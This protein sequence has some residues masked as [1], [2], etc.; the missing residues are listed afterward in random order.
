M[1]FKHQLMLGGALVVGAFAAGAHAQTR[2]TTA[3]A[4]STNTIEELVVTAEKREQ[5]LQDVPVAVSA[6]T[7]SKRELVGINSIQD[8]TNFTPGLQYNSSTDRVSLRG[9]GRQTNVLSADASVANYNDGVYETFAVQ[10]GRSTLFLDRVEVLRG[11]Q[12]T[13]YGRN[14]IGGAINEISKKPTETPFGEIRASYGNYNHSTLEA[15][16]SGPVTDK[17]QFRIAGDWEKQTEGWTKNII[18]GAPSEGNVINEWFLEGQVQGK[19][20]DDHLDVWAKYAGGQWYNGAGG[21]GSGSGGW[22]QAPYPTFETGVGATELNPGYACNPASG[23]T[24]VVN[25][26][27]AGC[28]N[29]AQKDPWHI[30]RAVPYKVDLPLYDTVAMHF[31][32]HAKN[33]DIKYITGGV[34]YHYHL[35]GPTGPAGT[36]NTATSPI[37]SYTLSGGTVIHPQESFDYREYNRFWSH[38]I[39]LI[40]TNDSP[41]QYVVGAYYFKQHYTQPVFTTNPNQP[42][43]NG[44]FGAPGFFCAQ[45]GGVCAPETGFRR[46]D[47]KPDVNAVSWAGF[48]QIDYKINPQWKLTAGLRYSHDRKYG[49]ESVRILCFAVPACFAAPELAPFIPGGIPVV[50]LTQLG[51]VVSAPAGTAADPLPRG[52]T[53]KTTYNAATGFATRH[54]DS[55]WGATTGTLGVEWQPDADTNAYAKYSRGYKSGGFNIGIFTVLSF[56]PWTDKE[57]VNSFEVGLKKTFNQNFQANVAVFRYDYQNLQIPIA[58]V[59]TAGGLSQAST[60]FYNVPKAISQGIE[61]ELTYQPIENLQFLFNYSYLD[62]YVE[63][64]TAIDIADP[65]ALDP[66]AKPIQTVAQCQAAVGTATPCPSDAFSVGVANGGFQRFQSLSGNRLPNSAKNKIAFNANYTWKLDVGNITG[67]VS[68]VWRDKQYG[69]LFT[70]S[71][72]EAPSWDQV[73][74]RVTWDSKDKKTRVIAS[75]KNLF[76]RLGYDAGAF[77]S[78]YVGTIDSAGGTP[79]VVNQGTFR[80][81]S[82]TPPRTYG[83]ELQY[84]FF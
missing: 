61:L 53:T 8:M 48:G 11:P 22:T 18:P 4:A 73:D 6:F 9:V 43:W 39:N 37:T 70:R 79:T 51:T 47:N 56:E 68:Y 28:V 72:T 44:P 80:T 59:A 17:I 23:V 55:D 26:S 75:V 67:S 62:A 34:D 74:A 5:S 50:D 41:L 7:A 14:S 25:I 81:F 77:G 63:H 38:E 42:Q 49:S 82:V 46:F 29:P 33:F 76:D 64:G 57:I 32:W 13:L 65:A 84:K 15:A 3:A 20:F 52:V 31:T 83:I 36:S 78:R 71:Y 1:R 58:S 2:P 54:Y 60:N 27:P 35:T 66:A 12:G 45:T 40:S 24:N 16:Y 69:T 21:P 19:F 10:A 30:A